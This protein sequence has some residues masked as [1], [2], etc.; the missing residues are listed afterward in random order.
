VRTLPP[1]ALDQQKPA[2]VGIYGRA[3]EDCELSIEFVRMVGTEA[4]EVLAPPAVVQI[5]K[6]NSVASYW[7]EVP[8]DTQI[9]GPA[10]VRVRANKGRFFWVDHAPGQGLFRVAIFDPD[11]GNRPLL[12]NGTHL[13]DVA[14]K[15][16][17][18]KAFAFPVHCF[19]GNAP[20]FTSNLFLRV[21]CAD[22]T[23]RYA[24]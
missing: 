20:V 12:L 14:A 16:I 22:L 10:G 17:T 23:L 7:A 6:S 13:L 2:K 9:G 15:S 21:Q 11:T 18:Q 3:P 4:A 1:L 24:R 8:K 19:D 5:K